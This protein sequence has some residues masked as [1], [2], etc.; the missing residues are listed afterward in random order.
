MNSDDFLDECRAKAQDQV[1]RAR[2]VME[3]IDDA[4]INYV[5]KGDLWTVGQVFDHM[6]MANTPYLATI[7]SQLDRAPREGPGEINHTFFGKMIMKHGGPE[8]NVPAPKSMVP[9]PPPTARERID[10]WFA[11]MTLFLEFI[12]RAKG[13]D[14]S[15]VKARNP[16]FK[17]ANMNLTDYFGIAVQHTERHIRQIEER[18]KESE[19]RTLDSH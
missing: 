18:S 5:P 8:G 17:L 14:L 11:Q 12:D 13:I 15:N 3:S 10:L 4:G 16:F 9:P 1:N 6:I 19:A 7:E 2:I